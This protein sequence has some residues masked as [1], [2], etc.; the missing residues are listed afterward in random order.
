VA[1]HIRVSKALDAEFDVTT[2]D[3]VAN[4]DWAEDITVRKQLEGPTFASWAQRPLKSTAAG[5]AGLLRR[6]GG[7]DL[8]GGGQEEVQGGGRQARDGARVPRD[9]RITLITLLI[10]RAVCGVKR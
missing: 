8:A 10:W 3:N 5:P 6:R 1:M 4:A 9:V 7:G 2:S